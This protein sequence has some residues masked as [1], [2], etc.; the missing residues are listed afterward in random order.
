MKV[1]EWLDSLTIPPGY[2]M[3]CGWPDEQHGITWEAYMDWGHSVMD[4]TTSEGE[5]I[6][7]FQSFDEWKEEQRT[8]NPDRDNLGFS[9]ERCDMCNSLPGDRHAAT[10][11]SVE[12]PANF[13][14]YEV[15]GDCI[16]FIANGDVPDFLEGN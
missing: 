6:G 12:N 14:A 9:H 13:L 10:A 3:V 8:E 5:D 1:Q 16:C 15:C 4:E 2:D 7:S 11:L